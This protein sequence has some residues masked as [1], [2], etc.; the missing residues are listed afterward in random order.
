MSKFQKVYGKL[1]RYL[2]DRG[3]SVSW[4]A[5]NKE[6]AEMG[7]WKYTACY[8]TIMSNLG[9]WRIICKSFPAP[10]IGACFRFNRLSADDFSRYLDLFK[11]VGIIPE[12]V[13]CKRTRLGNIMIIPRKGWDRFTVYSTLCL[14]RYA[15]SRP[16]TITAALRIQKETGLPWLQV[17]QYCMASQNVSAGHGFISLQNTVQAGLNPATGMSLCKFGRMPMEKR[18]AESVKYP[19]YVSVYFQKWIAKLNEQTNQQREG[20]W[21]TH[22]TPRYS[23][24]DVEE[25]LNPHYSPLFTDATLD[26]EGLAQLFGDDKKG[27]TSWVKTGQES[28]KKFFGN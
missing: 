23:F 2:S 17:Y 4:T 12:G 27:G 22:P 19:A 7:A 21:G 10:K 28:V 5:H 16:R 11:E 25:I 26:E 14:F 6:G 13:I 15:D 1:P 8:R 3:D 18:A 9:D 20:S 24:K